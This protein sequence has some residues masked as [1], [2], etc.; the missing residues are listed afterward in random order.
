[1][2]INIQGHL[3]TLYMVP[4]QSS[5]AIL[6]ST[7]NS[8]LKFCCNWSAEGKETNFSLDTFTEQIILNFLLT[9]FSPNSL[10]QFV[11]L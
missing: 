1:M 11:V 6:C 3:R 10:I 8:L 7:H 9:I 2:K 5:F 4:F